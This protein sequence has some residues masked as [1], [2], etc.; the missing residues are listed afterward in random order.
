MKSKQAFSIRL[1]LS[2]FETWGCIWKFFE[3]DLVLAELN[4]LSVKDVLLTNTETFTCYGPQKRLCTFKCTF[5]LRGP[6]KVIFT[7]RQSEYGQMESI[8][9]SFLESF[10]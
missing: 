9:N 7:D 3:Y 2:S 8:N 10:L 6:K 4:C 5:A 1:P